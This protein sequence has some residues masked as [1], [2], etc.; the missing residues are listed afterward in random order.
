[1][2]V[3][4]LVEMLTSMNQ[5]LDVLCSTEDEDILAEGQK[6]VLLEIE[7]TSIVDGEQVRDTKGRPSLR[8]GKADHSKSF[9]MINVTSDF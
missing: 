9:V 6:F 3:A 2:K 1:M 4:K 8:L 5:D 7:N